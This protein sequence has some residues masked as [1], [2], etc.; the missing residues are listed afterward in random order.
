MLMSESYF[1][2]FEQQNISKMIYNVSAL[3]W[4]ASRK[5]FAAKACFQFHALCGQ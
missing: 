3:N 5:I 4:A 1:N 2:H